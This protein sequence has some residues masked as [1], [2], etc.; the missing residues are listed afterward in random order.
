MF[1]LGLKAN[2]LWKKQTC[3]THEPVDPFVID[4]GQVFGAEASVQDCACTPVPVAW[5]LGKIC[6]RRVKTSSWHISGGRPRRF[7]G[8]SGAL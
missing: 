6:F 1:A 8:L 5:P 2:A 4:G 3:A 7:F